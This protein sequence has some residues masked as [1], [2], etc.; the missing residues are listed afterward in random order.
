[1]SSYKILYTL[2]CKNGL[3]HQNNRTEQTISIYNIK[4]FILKNFQCF[5]K[6]KMKICIL[7]ACEQNQNEQI[8]LESW[9]HKAPTTSML[10]FKQKCQVYF[11]KIVTSWQLCPNPI[12]ADV[13]NDVI[14]PQQLRK[15]FHQNHYFLFLIMQNHVIYL[16]EHI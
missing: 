7:D 10:L 15:L 16:I 12:F 2:V 4:C 13:L 14:E 9:K 5:K 3:G 1:M 6:C 8:E 11:T